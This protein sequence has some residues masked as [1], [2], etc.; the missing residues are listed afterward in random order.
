[1][2]TRS[3]GGPR[4]ANLSLRLEDGPGERRRN[5]RLARQRLLSRL[6]AGGEKR[7]LVVPLQRHEAVIAKWSISGLAPPKV[8]LIGDRDQRRASIPVQAAAALVMMSLRRELP[9]RLARQARRAGIAA[10]VVVPR[11][12]NSDH[13]GL[14]SRRPQP[15]GVALDGGNRKAGTSRKDGDRVAR[16]VGERRRARNRAR[17]G[18]RQ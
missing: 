2:P 15:P 16:L 18:R 5:P 12:W 13:R 11:T 8:D 6:R 17:G 4:G 3:N 10:L 1:M 9:E 14:R 7:R